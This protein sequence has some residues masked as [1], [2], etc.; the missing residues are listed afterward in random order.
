MNFT[1]FISVLF[2]QARL[3]VHPTSNVLPPRARSAVLVLHLVLPGVRVLRVVVVVFPVVRLGKPL[4]RLLELLVPRRAL[5]EEK[6]GRLG[7]AAVV[8]VLELLVC[9]LVLGA[10]RCLTARLTR[11]TCLLLLL[12]LGLLLLQ[13]G[14]VRMCPRPVFVLVLVASE[15]VT[16][17]SP[18]QLV[19]PVHLVL[20]WR[21][22]VRVAA[23]RGAVPGAVVV[24]LGVGDAVGLMK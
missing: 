11:T 18:L 7:P 2:T 13:I 6:R 20:L 22:A 21:A 17:V 19:A 1:S 4:R 5:A 10:V 15:I 9:M 14:L 24:L 3:K 12:V 8:R 23:V 16:V